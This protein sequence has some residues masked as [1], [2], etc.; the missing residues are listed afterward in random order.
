MREYL[1]VSLLAVGAFVWSEGAEAQWVQQNS[2]IDSPLTGVVMI[3]TMTAYAV[4]H[5]R[6]ILRTTNRGD[7]W[8]DLTAPLSYVMPW[9]AVDF[10]DSANGM[11]VGD[12]GAVFTIKGGNMSGWCRYIT[13]GP[14]C[15]SVLY[16]DPSNIYVGADSGRIYHS[17]DSGR[18]WSAEKISDWPIR[19]LFIWHGNYTL[20]PIIYALTSHSI[21]SKVEFPSTP[22]REEVLQDFQVPGSE[23]FDGEFCDDAGSGFIVGF[24]GSSSPS[25]VILRKLPADTSWNSVPCGNQGN[26]PLF[27][28]SAPSAG[29][30]YACGR[31]GM[32]IKS[33]D[34]GDSWSTYVLPMTMVKIPDLNAIYFI[35]EKHGF[36]VGEAGTI[37]YTSNGGT[38]GIGEHDPNT[39]VDFILEQNYPNPF[40]PSTAISYKLSAVSNVTLK[41][42]D[43][44]GREV[45]TLSDGV[46]QSAGKHSLRWDGT[47]Q[48][49]ERVGSG[50]YY[51]RLTTDT[52]A[53]TKKAVYLR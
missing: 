16:V 52:G 22:W 30:I 43:V 44:L 40:N 47:N 11:A 49:G 38:T 33:T 53:Q 17:L 31:S 4:S 29:A 39:P 9:N 14:N 37:L 41:I 45:I 15:L 50:I 5:G 6:S 18:T 21:C 7:T 10:Y 12:Y 8:V 32:I 26:G 46:R 2:G 3:D 24:G 51:Y 25:P 35:D 36:A 1:L 13:Y 19:S 48:R 42:F 23:A 27:G 34:G 20:G 28:V